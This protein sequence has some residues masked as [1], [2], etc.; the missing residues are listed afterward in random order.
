[1]IQR[2]EREYDIDIDGTET[3]VYMGFSVLL[4]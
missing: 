4:R 1:M 3:V 2:G